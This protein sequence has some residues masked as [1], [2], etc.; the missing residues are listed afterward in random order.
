MKKKIGTIVTLMLIVSFVKIPLFGMPHKN[1]MPS[2][3]G[4]QAHTMQ[5]QQTRDIV[6][7]AA[8]DE[9]F[10]T[11]VAALQAADL[12]ETLKGQGP[13][14]VFAPT[15][16]AFAKLPA[17]TLEDLLKPENKST[18]VDILTYHVFPGNV[19]AADVVNLDGQD[20]TMAN[21]DKARIQ[22]RNGE[23]FINGARVIATDIVA[24]NGV[25]HVIDTVILPPTE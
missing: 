1:T 17:G 4:Q 18:L 25:I 11:L 7:V 10:E 8:A 14:T 15:D 19:L 20:I 3:G 5:G 24:S 22:V 6:D 13:F 23:V 2:A 16:D 21:G 12:V 9:R